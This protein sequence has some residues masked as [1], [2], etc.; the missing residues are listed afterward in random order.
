MTLSTSTDGA[1]GGIEGRMDVGVFSEYC[2]GWMAETEM[3]ERLWNA[4]YA[5]AQN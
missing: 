1:L 2:T 3:P 4:S 5:S